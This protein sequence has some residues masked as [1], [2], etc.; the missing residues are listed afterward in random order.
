MKYIFGPVP[1]RRLGSSLG[2]D[3][4]P[5]KICTQNCLYCE[6]GPTRIL[7]LR[8]AEWVPTDE[9]IMELKD[10]LQDPPHIDYITFSGSGEPLLHSKIG[11]IIDFLKDN[12]PYKVAILT[13]S[14]LLKEA[15]KEILRAD[16]IAPSLDAA[17]EEDFRKVN[18]PHPGIK[19]KDILEGL[20]LLSE[21]F[22]GE[23]HIEVLLVKGVND[24]R[25][26]IEAIASFLKKLKN[27][28]SIQ[29]NTVDRPPAYPV[30]PLNY[31]ELQKIAIHIKEKTGIPTEVVTRSESIK[32]AL[33]R[34]DV[35][36]TLGR[37]PMTT[38]QLAS[39]IGKSPEETERQL[40]AL[41][42]K[43]FVEEKRTGSE[44]FWTL[45]KIRKRAQS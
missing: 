26:N 34:F 5:M 20:E 9:V 11:K 23:I 37:R 13:N 30:K 35:L 42:R 31:E 10:F 43:G 16:L 3:L 21:N 15:Y 18:M 29:L 41:K 44:L 2:I 36:S 38:E 25:K 22:K 7:T 8:R 27:I 17:T 39:L 24:D 14:T 33:S 19:L 6:C 28:D 32:E 45:K 40:Q 12:Y 4:L 1:S